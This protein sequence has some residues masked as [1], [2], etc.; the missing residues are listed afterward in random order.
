MTPIKVLHVTDVE[1]DD[2]HLKNLS[3]YLKESIVEFSFVTLGSSDSALVRGMNKRGRKAFG[4]NSVGRRSYPRVVKSLARLFK[5]LDS[6]IVHTNLFDPSLIGLTIAKVQ[7]R[8]T[9]LTRHHSDAVHK[10]ASPL[11]RKF[12]LALDNYISRKADHIIAPSQMVRDILVEDEKV[13]SEK[14]TII[15]YAQT[16]ERF[17]PV[18]PTAVSAKRTELRMDE[19]L[20]LVCV[21]R[22]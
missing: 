4:L 15:P 14:V 13:P 11:K 3:D 5:E 21:S 18:T 19:Q 9:F 2:Y 8:K 16:T 20:A 12:Y 10:I 17:D 6:D 22:L 7:G 1:V